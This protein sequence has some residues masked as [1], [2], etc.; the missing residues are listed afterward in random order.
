MAKAYIRV[1]HELW[2]DLQA[3]KYDK[4]FKIV[5]KEKL[6]EDLSSKLLHI[7]SETIP[8]NLSGKMLSLVIERTEPRT[9]KPEDAKITWS[10][11]D[12]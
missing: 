11:I 7:E 6:M 8:E 2:Q 4:V 3:M 5:L 12:E 9:D 10:E 1:T